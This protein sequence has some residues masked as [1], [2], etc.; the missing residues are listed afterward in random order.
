MRILNKDACARGMNHMKKTILLLFVLIIFHLIVSSCGVIR[1]G[2]ALSRSP[3]NYTKIGKYVQIE[4]K[5]DERFGNEICNVLPH[6]IDSVENK[7]LHKFVNPPI[8]YV[9]NSNQSFCKYSG[10]KYPGPRARALADKVFIS[11]RLNGSKDWN[12]IVYHELSHALLYQCI[13]AYHY[14]KIPVWFHEGLATYISN[15]GGSGNITDNMAIL[16]ILKGNHFYPKSFNNNTIPAWMKYRQAMLFVKFMKEGK[17]KEFEK[18]LTAIFNKKSF[19]KSIET[20]Y[21]MK[22]SKLWIEFIDKLKK[23]KIQGSIGVE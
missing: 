19:S 5:S 3:N 1:T 8:I 22:V 4:N 23:D 14:I 9:C 13:V 20:S 12:E 17:E 18:L 2:I 11:P 7:L 6:L 21:G 10:S 15:G 16:D